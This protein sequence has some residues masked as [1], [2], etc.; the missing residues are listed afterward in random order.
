MTQSRGRWW[1]NSNLC[2]YYARVTAALLVSVGLIAITGGLS[3]QFPSGIYH[4]VIGLLFG[5]VGFFVRDLEAVRQTVGRLGVLLLIVKVATILVPL[6]WEEHLHWGSIEVTCLV[7]GI[8]SILAAR[9]LR[10]AEP[11]STIR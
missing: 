4:V 9:Y 8:T 5:Y 6:L 10:D 3:W 2:R 11:R 1:K 7:V